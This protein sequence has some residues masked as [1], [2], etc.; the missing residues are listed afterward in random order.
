MFLVSAALAVG[1]YAAHGIVQVILAVLAG[2][3][4]A[5]ALWSTAFMTVARIVQK[6][7]QR[8]F[9]DA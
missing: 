8:A 2:V 6:R 5:V 1:A 4:F 9:P 7:M 3:I